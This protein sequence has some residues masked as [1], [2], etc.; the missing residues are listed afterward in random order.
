MGIQRDAQRLLSFAFLLEVG[1]PEKLVKKS[2][3]VKPSFF[4]KRL[5]LCVSQHEGTN[6]PLVEAALLL[7]S[8]RP[9]HPGA[10]P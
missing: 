2:A 10:L 6:L 1:L 5:A 7:A 9:Y 8:E 4:S 3:L